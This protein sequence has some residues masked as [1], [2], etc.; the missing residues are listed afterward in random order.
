M[1]AQILVSWIGHTDI[2]ALALA[3]PAKQRTE[4]ESLVGSSSQV[5]GDGPIKALIKG[6]RFSQIHLI[7]ASLDRER[8]CLEMRSITQVT[9]AMAR[10]YR[11][12]VPRSRRTCSNPSFL[13]T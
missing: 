9:G 5:E 6:E 1:A 4:L 11:S 13:A 2:R 10:S 7:R 3:M 8:N 12:T